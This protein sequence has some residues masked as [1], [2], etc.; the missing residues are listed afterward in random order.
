[1]ADDW[2]TFTD[3]DRP[4]VISLY[5]YDANSEVNM[6]LNNRKESQRPSTSA[7][8]KSTQKGKSRGGTAGYTAASERASEAM[9]EAAANLMSQ[10]RLLRQRIKTDK[11]FRDS[12]FSCGVA[13]ADLLPKSRDHFRT[14]PGRVQV[15]KRSEQ[16]LRFDFFN[17][18]R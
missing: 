8:L 7:G 4:V 6:Y 9:L 10:P 5:Q 15:L 17:D 14:L 3:L 12:C 18:D 13:P 16:K 2:E 1:M 11:T